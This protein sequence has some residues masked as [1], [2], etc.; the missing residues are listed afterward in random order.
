MNMKRIIILLLIL[1][2]VIGGIFCYK[3]YK[4]ENEEVIVQSNLEDEKLL[5]LLNG[6]SDTVK[7]YLDKNI[8]EDE[9]K[10]IEKELKRKEYINS[11]KYISPED[12]LNI[13]KNQYKENSY[14]LDGYEGENNIFPASYQIKIVFNSI[15]DIN[16]EY[17]DYI[18]KDLKK[19]EN[20]DKVVT[21]IKTYLSVYE[22]YGMDAL[23]EYIKNGVDALKKYEK[24]NGK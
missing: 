21:S 3:Y 6:I 16:D 12:A 5:E 14:I 20:I 22:K 17:F 18:E 4:D 11:V 1:V 8:S 24:D 2:F 7:V 15:D 10:K 23:E 19:I 13:M 9:I